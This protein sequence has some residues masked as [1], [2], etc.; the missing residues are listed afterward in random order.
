[1]VYRRNLRSKRWIA[2][3]MLPMQ[4]GHAEQRTHDYA[5][6]GTAT[7]FVAL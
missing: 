4:P 5:R 1:M 7:Q 2:Q 6:H 3:K